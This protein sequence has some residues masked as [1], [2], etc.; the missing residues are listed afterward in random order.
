MAIGLVIYAMMASA[1]FPDFWHAPRAEKAK[2]WDEEW[3]LEPNSPER[4]KEA[5]KTAKYLALKPQ[6]TEEVTIE[7]DV[8]LGADHRGKITLTFMPDGKI[9]GAWESQYAH[10]NIEYTVMASFAGV[11]DPTNIMMEQDKKRPEMLYFITRGG[12]VQKSLDTKNDVEGKEEGTAYAA[13]WMGA[14]MASRG[15]IT[16]T[17]DRTGSAIYTFNTQIKK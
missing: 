3:R 6:I 8:M 12:Y 16:L 17:T 14:D 11:T 1:I 15:E 7:G 4:M 5:K 13:G 2:V 9:K 10:G